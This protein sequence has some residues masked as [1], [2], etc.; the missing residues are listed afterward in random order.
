MHGRKTLK[1]DLIHAI[2]NV[3]SFPLAT[4]PKKWTSFQGINIKTNFLIKMLAQTH[5]DAIKACC[6]LI[7]F[8]IYI[9][10]T[11]YIS[12]WKKWRLGMR[13]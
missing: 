7:I 6:L 3:V 12:I 5:L 11:G 9:E 10:Y 13:M 4:V 1:K 8:S 2:T